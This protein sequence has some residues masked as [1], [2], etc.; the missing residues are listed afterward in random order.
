MIPFAGNIWLWEQDQEFCGLELGTRMTVI[1]L[2]RNALFVHSPIRLNATIVEQLKKLGDVRFVVCPNKFHHL[3]I[4][5]FKNHFPEAQFFCAPGLDK[6]RQDVT[7]DAVITNQ[8]DLP[9]NTEL[10]HA[11]V[12]GIPMINEVV[13]HHPA[14]KSLIIT[15]LS[16]NMRESSSL[17]TKLLLKLIGAYGHFG[18]SRLERWAFIRNRRKFSASLKPIFNWD[19]ERIVLAHGTLI[20]ANGKE[21]FLQAF[22]RYS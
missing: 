22:R 21:L 6:K 14:S 11:V 4:G 8:Q 7:F 15:D 12:D 16:L 2:D 20:S 19:F 10:A 9:W 18:L 17:K 13:F 3:Y 1:R 5:D